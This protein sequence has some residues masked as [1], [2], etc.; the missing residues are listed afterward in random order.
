[1]TSNAEKDIHHFH[2]LG[3]NAARLTSSL[4]VGEM[5]HSVLQDGEMRVG[6]GLSCHQ[7]DVD[8]MSTPR[9]HGEGCEVFTMVAITL[10]VNRICSLDK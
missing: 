6:R 1:M 9:V 8:Q 3:L 5:V 2:S 4:V 7:L 10:P